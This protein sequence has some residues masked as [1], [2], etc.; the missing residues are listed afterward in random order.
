MIAWRLS[1]SEHI[2]SLHLVH[3]R[4]H[5]HV[6]A[7]RSSKSLP[8]FFL[9]CMAKFA[10]GQRWLLLQA[11]TKKKKIMSLPHDFNSPLDAG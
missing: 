8:I 4:K 3:G 10:A 1:L 6:V 2:V 11:S 5:V 7:N 9:F